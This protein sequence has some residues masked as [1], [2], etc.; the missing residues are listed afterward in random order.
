[1]I[2]ERD[3]VDPRPD[4]LLVNP[5]RDSRAVRRILRVGHDQIEPLALAQLRQRFAHDAT[6]GL[7]D[8]ISNEQDPHGR[9]LSLDFLAGCFREA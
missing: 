3:A 5:R 8:D 4:Q 1:M 6:A 9:M 2:P 7:A